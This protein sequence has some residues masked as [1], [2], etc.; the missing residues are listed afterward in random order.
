MTASYLYI[1]DIIRYFGQPIQT[2]ETTGLFYTKFCSIS[3]L[4]TINGKIYDF[5]NLFNIPKTNS[6]Y[7]QTSFNEKN[8]SK[9]FIHGN[10]YGLSKS[11]KYNLTFKVN[12]TDKYNYVI[13][14]VV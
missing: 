1:N 3:R 13:N 2:I 14:Q 10:F 12:V 7:V 11:Q 4:N 8:N 9:K 6:I 5:H